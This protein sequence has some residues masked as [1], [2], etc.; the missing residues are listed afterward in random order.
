[1]KRIVHTFHKEGYVQHTSNHVNPNP[2]TIEQLCSFLDISL[3]F[4]RFLV[5]TNSSHEWSVNF[6]DTESEND[7][8]PKFVGYGSTQMKS[9]ADL[10]DKIKG[11]KLGLIY[12]PD[13]VSLGHRGYVVRKKEH[14]HV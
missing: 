10:V 9:L 7:V 13:V 1:M 3:K 14:Q 2:V 8:W 4:R 5:H 12:I 11:Q 6:C